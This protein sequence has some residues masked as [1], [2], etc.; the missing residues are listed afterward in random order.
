MDVLEEIKDKKEFRGLSDEL[1]L[2]VINIYRSKY[3][4]EVEKERKMLVKDCRAKLRELYSAFRLGGYEKRIK[5]LSQM[6]NWYDEDTAKKILSLHLSSK[7]RL[8]Y[9]PKLYK[10]LRSKIQF[11]TVLDIGCGMNVFSMPWM[12]RVDYYG[13]DVNKEDVDFCND[14]LNKFKITGGVRC[15]DIMS[16]DNVIKTDVC[17]IFKV[18]EGLEGIERNITTKL[19]VKITSPW[20]VV[21]FATRSLGGGKVISARRLKWFEELVKIEEKFNLGTEVYYIIKNY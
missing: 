12:G 2:K 15:A 21:S 13:I 1:V 19:F 4:I 20:I 11:K 17:F 7:E 10:K 18:L 9:Y 5:Y 6:K 14:Y 3:N 8:N 16:L